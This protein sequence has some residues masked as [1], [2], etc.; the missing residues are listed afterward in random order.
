MSDETRDTIYPQARISIDFHRIG[1]TVARMTGM[2]IVEVSASSQ[3]SPTMTS[4]NPT[5]THDEKPKFR[6]HPGAEN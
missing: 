5:S 1:I 4:T 6:S 3:I 2:T